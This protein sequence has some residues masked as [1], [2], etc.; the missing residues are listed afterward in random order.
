MGNS[1]INRILKEGSRWI[2]T[3]V[4]K[5]KH[6]YIIHSIAEVIT[7]NSHKLYYN[8]MK[9]D[10]C[11]SFVAI[12]IEGNPLGLII[13]NNYDKSLPIIRLESTH[14]YPFDFRY[15]IKRK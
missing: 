4:G 8:V 2:D 15:C 13:D 7:A 1:K 6:N 11:D 9:C 5:H 3:S 12:P 10:I 14:K